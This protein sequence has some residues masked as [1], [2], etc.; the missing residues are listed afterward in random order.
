MTRHRSAI[1]IATVAAL[2]TAAPPAAADD[3]T[4]FNAYVARQASEVDPA[5]E[6]YLRATR[7]V[8]KAKTPRAARRAFRAV[9][10]ADKRINRALRNVEADLEAQQASS[11]HGTRARSEGLK[12]VRG[13]QLAN[14]LEMRV[15]R[16]I[17]RGERFSIRR[18]LRRPNKIMRRV[19][20]NGRRAV[21]NFRAVGLTSPV[22]AVSAK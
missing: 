5:G 12:E 4:L 7:R 9:I 10:R 17:L 1:L 14:R 18:A 3:A 2:L 13:W 20:G 22:G 6:A 8:G 21:R 15:V 16:R 11:E 19:Y